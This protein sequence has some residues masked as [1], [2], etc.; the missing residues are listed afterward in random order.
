MLADSTRSNDEAVA[1]AAGSAGKVCAVAHLVTLCGLRAQA[2][3]AREKPVRFLFLAARKKKAAKR[4]SA[5]LK[6]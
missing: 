2:R 1:Y 3:C 5:G 4:K 6:D